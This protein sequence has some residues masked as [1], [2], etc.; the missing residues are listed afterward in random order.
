M[1]QNPWFFSSKTDNGENENTLAIHCI[2]ESDRSQFNADEIIAVVGCSLS[3][4][5]EEQ[6]DWNGYFDELESY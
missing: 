6:S 2:A 5:G 4:L 3:N 1:S